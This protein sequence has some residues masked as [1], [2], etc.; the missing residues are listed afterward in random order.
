MIF[1]G[2]GVTLTISLF[3]CCTAASQQ[4]PST[5]SPE[6]PSATAA[7]PSSQPEKEI[8]RQIRKSEQSQRILGVVPMFGTTNRR[9]PPPLTVGQKFHLFAKS[10]FD[11]FVF[12]TSGI[13]AGIGQ[14]QDDF[15]GYGQGVAGYTKRYAATFGD[16]T[17]ATFFGAFLYPV[18]LKQDP[19][20]FRLG[21]GTAKRRIGYALAQA[22]VC[23]TDKGGRAFNF[24]SVLGAFSSGALSN[25]YYPP[26]DRGFGL[27]MSRTGISM[28]YGSAGGLVDEFWPDIH[29]KFFEK[30]KKQQPTP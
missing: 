17:S 25:A 19:R 18:L 2:R 6:V 9:D 23:H 8:E 13:Q 16:S 24:S 26:S 10:A 27:T 30:K 20:Y 12:A 15:P 3:V 22:F 4:I 5:T 7:A 11:P 1:G 28:I 29:H 14:A 21:Q